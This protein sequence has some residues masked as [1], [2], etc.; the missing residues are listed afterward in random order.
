[1][2]RWEACVDAAYT[3]N[4]LT[5]PPLKRKQV[6]SWLLLAKPTGKSPRNKLRSP[7]LNPGI[8]SGPVVT[9]SAQPSISKTQNPGRFGGNLSCCPTSF[10]HSVWSYFDSQGGWSVR[11][12]SSFFT[13][14]SDLSRTTVVTGGTDRHRESTEQT[15][16]L[17]RQSLTLQLLVA[18]SCCCCCCCCCC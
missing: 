5:P 3:Y 8:N 11:S 1:M 18:D 6:H 13:I 17:A 2:C 15:N 12:V 10:F 14:S 16:Q 7:L 9:V 4:L